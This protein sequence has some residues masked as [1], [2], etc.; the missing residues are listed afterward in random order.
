MTTGLAVT[1]EGGPG[2]FAVG[3]PDD[4]IKLWGDTDPATEP[5]PTIRDATAHSAGRDARMAPNL[6]HE[7]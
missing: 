6:A 4:T 1:A 7:T 3:V 2:A 5:H